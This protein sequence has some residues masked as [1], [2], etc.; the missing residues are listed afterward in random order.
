MQQS[1]PSLS[2]SA[3]EP[4][5]DVPLQDEIML[6]RLHRQVRGRQRSYQRLRDRILAACDEGR[7]YLDLTHPLHAWQLELLTDKGYIVV[8]NRLC[9]SLAAANRY[10][11]EC[12]VPVHPTV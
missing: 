6:H 8:N 5:P 4:E 12:N 9:F 10:R 1:P 7:D 3:P 11:R 2:A